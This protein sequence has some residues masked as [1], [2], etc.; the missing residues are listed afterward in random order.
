MRLGGPVLEAVHSPQEWVAALKKLGYRSAFCP[1]QPGASSAEISAYAE[2]ARRSDIV[3]AEVGVWNNPIDPDP[4]KSRKARKDCQEALALADEIGA[5]CCVNCAGT[6]NPDH[7]YGPHL[8]NLSQRGIEA[9][10]EAARVIIDAV[11]PK[12]TFYSLEP[13]GFILPDSAESY[14]KIIAAVDREHF[15]V[16]YD[17]VNLVS[18]PHRYFSQAELIRDFIRRLGPRIKSCHVK[19][20]RL[21][22]DLTV[23]LKEVRAGLGEFDCG[24]FLAEIEKL[25]PE[26]PVLL[27]HL[28]KAE[29][30]R[31]AGEYV[32]KK[33]R[34]AGIPGK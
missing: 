18:T 8:D 1:V 24:T 4:V 27:E 33:M 20:I 30:Y 25:D 15:G 21:M 2:A 31:L 17:P 23:Y 12:R 19:D 22:T 26:M 7:W 9:V 6:F 34:E 32:R 10:A 13:M 11:K 14:E 28:E 3:I 5:K 16:H 29:D